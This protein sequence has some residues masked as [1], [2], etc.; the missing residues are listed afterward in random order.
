MT[1]MCVAL[2]DGEQ[3]VK[4]LGPR[5]S[6]GYGWAPSSASRRALASSPPANPVSLPVEP[7]T[8]WHGATIDTGFLPFAA[9]TARTA[10]GLPICLRDLSVGS[11]LAERDR[12]QRVPHLAL[13]RRAGDDPASTRTPSAGRRSIPRAGAR[14]RRSTGWPVVL[15]LDVQ[16]HP[17]RAVVLPQDRG[18]AVVG[19]N[20]L[21]PSDRRVH[22]LVD[23]TLLRVP[24]S[25]LAMA[26]SSFV[27]ASARFATS[28]VRLPDDIRPPP[29]RARHFRTSTPN[30]C[31][32][33]KMASQRCVPSP[34]GGFM[35]QDS[36]RLYNA[37]DRPRFAIRRRVLRRRHVDRHL[38]PADLSGE[39]AE[40]GQL[41][42]LRHA[43][44]G[45]AG[46]LP[47]LPALPAGAG[48]G[49]R[50]GGRCAAHRAADRA[51]ARGR[52]PRREGGARGDR[53][54]SSSSAR[55][56]FAASCRRSWACRRSSCC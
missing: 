40:G 5:R 24:R 3:V 22:H 41:P 17:A 44:G 54:T 2:A 20:Q 36:R 48:A 37:L 43:A 9:P 16:P 46:R 15:R 13:K 8:R 27:D 7:M 10:A 4:A 21:Q 42:L 38:L 6:A 25:I 30:R 39:D 53:R 49:Q 52:A 12:Q 18:E 56:R 51:A 19:R 45:R 33:P 34:Y 32:C 55:G 26:R 11:R 35:D 29:T 31:R 47:A 23:V 28:I 50:A 14:S 1:V